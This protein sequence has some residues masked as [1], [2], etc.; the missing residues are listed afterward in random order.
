MFTKSESANDNY[1]AEIVK[2]E[3]ITPHANADKLQV[4]HINGNAVITDL[5]SQVG[6]ISVYFPLECA[7]ALE[8]LSKNNAFRDK[9]LNADPEK[10]GFYEAHG[11]CRA[12][13]LRN[14]PSEGYLVP[15]ET[16]AMWLG[17]TGVISAAQANVGARFDSVDGQ[18]LCKKFVPK[19]ANQ[20]AAGTKT[21]KQ[22][23]DKHVF[24]KMVDGQFALHFDTAQLGRN[25][26]KINPDTLLSITMKLH[27]TSA[28]VGNVICKK[29]LGWFQRL[30]KKLG[31]DIV[32]T[33]YQMVYSSRKVIKNAHT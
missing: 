10:S 26:F 25:M 8:Y 18:L 4:V 11:R 29:Q 3:K 27:G 6:Q 12:V 1:L 33:E 14:Q 23:R 17:S 22:K 15:V 5:T 32:D 2:I 16:L 13:R 24:N 7:I 9:T 21:A 30:L 31:A 19:H 20:K 28:V